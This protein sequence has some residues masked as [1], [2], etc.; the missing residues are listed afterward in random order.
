[1]PVNCLEKN[2]RTRHAT[3]AAVLLAS[4]TLPALAQQKTLRFIPQADLR[5]LDPIVT[6]AGITRNHAYLIY[7]TLFGTDE[8][9]RVHPQMVERWEVS[10]DQLTYTFTLRD[11]LAFH[12]GQKV[13]S[14]DCIASLTRWGKRDALGQRLA[15]V[16][17][18]WTAI[19]DQTFRL[20]L[21][22]AFPRTLEALGELS[23]NVP[24]IMPERV[25]RTDP[26]QAIT[27]TIGSG[28]FKFVKE[29][30]VPGSKVVYVRNA[31]YVPRTE[32]ASWAAGGKIAK[33]DRIEWVYIPDAATAA[34]AI[35]AGEADWWEV[36]PPDLAPL[37]RKNKAVR[38]EGK[39]PLGSVAVMRFNHLQPPFNNAKLRKALLQAVDQKDYVLAIAG[40]QDLGRECYSM[41]A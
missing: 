2:H 19:D 24:F 32:R 23:S 27:A 17:Q 6:T 25:A 38:I 1:M 4:V 31:Q 37:L 9:L 5:V 3:I 26:Y 35:N 40:G 41:Y 13:R 39:D 10:K 14:A 16:T 22:R 12:D 11:G 15:A 29:E 34:A 7:D 8:N 28:P 21:T 18:S 33:V 20:R 30:W 36:M